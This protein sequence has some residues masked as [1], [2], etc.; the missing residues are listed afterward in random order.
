MATPTL[1]VFAREPIAGQVKTRL[2]RTIGHEAALALHLAFVE[3][4]CALARAAERRL[5]AVA[6]DPAHPDLVRLAEQY[7]LERVAQPEG[8]LGERMATVLSVR[9][10]ACIIGSDAPTLSRAHLEAALAALATHEVVLGP[11]TDGGYWLIGL[12]EPRPELFSAMP[13]STSSVMSETLRRLSGVPTAILPFH[14]DVDDEEGLAMLRA[15]LLHL[16]DEVAP[17]TRRALARLTL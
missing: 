11:A 4:A 8:D 14:Y 6:G 1:V 10:P 3:D 12:R 17:A 15:H 2:A 7:G 9:A 13:W 16:P 5:L